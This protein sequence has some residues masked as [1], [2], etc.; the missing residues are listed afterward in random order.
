MAL[1]AA[2]LVSAR[3]E[4]GARAVASSPQRALRGPHFRSSGP[5][6]GKGSL[7]LAPGLL[8]WA[9]KN[10]LQSTPSG[11]PVPLSLR[12]PLSTRKRAVA[13][14]AA[15]AKRFVYSHLPRYSNGLQRSKSSVPDNHTPDVR[16]PRTRSGWVGSGSSG[17]LCRTRT[18]SCWV[19]SG[20]SGWLC[21]T[22][23]RSG[24]VDSGSR[25]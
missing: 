25:G 1:T 3:P 23:T 14:P 24:C 2:L 5:E 7:A 10:R 9:S 18:R 19:G 21:R 17:W 12:I 8:A 16:V 4:G 11:N 6:I 15:T 20:S 22:R 13:M